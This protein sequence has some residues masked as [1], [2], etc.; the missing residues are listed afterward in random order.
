MERRSF[1]RVLAAVAAVPLVGGA[2]VLARMFAPAGRWIMPG[3]PPARP[4]SFLD[5]L[6]EVC[7][8]PAD[9]VETARALGLEIDLDEPVELRNYVATYRGP[10]P[11]EA[12]KAA[13]DFWRP[14]PDGEPTEQEIE[15]RIAAYERHCLGPH[16]GTLPTSRHL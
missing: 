12:E 11:T 9:D 3:G 5:P 15:A 6:G 4:V 14:Y 8:F 10:K 2:R 16:R 13:H 1:F 7:V